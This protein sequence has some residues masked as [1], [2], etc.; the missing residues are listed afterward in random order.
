MESAVVYFKSF[1]SCNLNTAVVTMP[2]RWLVL[3]IIHPAWNH[4]PANGHFDLKLMRLSLFIPVMCF[5]F[6]CVGAYGIT[7]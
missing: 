6:C 4:R 1:M 7:T 3:L 2:E 5:F